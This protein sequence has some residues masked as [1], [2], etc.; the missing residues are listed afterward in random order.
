MSKFC[1]S[2]SKENKNGSM[3]S[4][5]LVFLIGFFVVSACSTFSEQMQPVSDAC[6]PY[7]DFIKA[8][9]QRTE[10][11]WYQFKSEEQIFERYRQ[12]DFLYP[13]GGGCLMGASKQFIRDLF[14]SPNYETVL[15]SKGVNLFNYCME[16]DCYK[17]YQI[18]GLN[19]PGLVFFFDEE[20]RVEDIYIGRDY[21]LLYFNQHEAYIIE[22]LRKD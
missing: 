11:G 20:E 4:K 21:R 1:L 16:E 7:Y 14:G 3:Q 5:T 19:Y 6:Q 10:G 15:R 8:E 17:T 9:W 12:G 13:F 18:T 22:K 2:E